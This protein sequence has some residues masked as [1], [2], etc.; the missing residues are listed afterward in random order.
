[1]LKDLHILLSEN[2]G[3]YLAE[4]IEP[5]KDATGFATP[6]GNGWPVE[7]VLPPPLASGHGLT[8][9]QGVLLELQPG[10][11]INELQDMGNYLF[12]FLFGPKD[13]ENVLYQY[14]LASFRQSQ[15][16]E[17]MR[18]VLHL[19]SEMLVGVPWELL[20][21]DN[22]LY[23][24]ALPNPKPHSLLRSRWKADDFSAPSIALPAALEPLRVLLIVCHS[25]DDD[26][27]IMG[28]E[29]A[30]KVDAALFKLLPWR[31]DLR[32]LV[33]PSFREVRDWCANWQPHVFHYVGHGGFN[34]NGPYLQFF[35]PGQLDTIPIDPTAMANFFTGGAPRLVVLNA[36]RSGQVA[37][38]IISASNSARASQSL[39]KVLIEGGVEAVI[40]MQADIDGQAA[41]YLMGEFYH[42][43]A[44]GGP[45]DL[46]L[47]AARQVY[48]GQAGLGTKKWDWA[49]PALYLSG[50]SRV[51]DVLLLDPNGTE[52]KIF[53]VAATDSDARRRLLQDLQL[54]VKIQVGR[55]KEQVALE[56]A[57]LKADFDKIAP[58][59][60]LYGEPFMGKTNMLY[61][62]SEGCARRGRQ[63]IYA[64]FAQTTLDYWD[65]LR[66]IRDG[67]L[68]PKVNGVALSNALNPDLIFN[69]FNY[70][71]NSKLVKGYATKNRVAPAL[72]T[73]VAD[74]TRDKKAPRELE[75]LGTVRSNEN[76]IETINEAF[77]SSLA[78]AADPHG[79]IIFLD[80]VDSMFSGEVNKLRNYL[81]N[82]VLASENYPN[83]R[84]VRMVLAVRSPS[85]DATTPERPWD[86]LLDNSKVVVQRLAGLPPQDLSWLARL[87]ARRYFI[88]NG[89]PLY[90]R[91]KKLTT[92]A[93]DAY[94]SSLLNNYYLSRAQRPGRLISD[95][96][97]P[98]RIADLLS[99][100][101]NG[102]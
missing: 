102:V 33:R 12:H 19:D 23:L 14:W 36:C 94:V 30:L 92:Q 26:G 43:L 44:E 11:A 53:Q 95:L 71:L 86:F 67:R 82:Q 10:D 81:V 45:L 97:N 37:G 66:L 77:W 3:K 51:E 80:N 74:L 39:A 52:A 8:D 7:L 58:V 31:V 88:S 98:D 4:V 6:T 46:A 100:A 90:M 54:R 17:G 101:D 42:K 55:D 35:E 83:A 68:E 62:L 16:E 64:D 13:H 87:W 72:N 38:Q 99:S 9:F 1:M 34:E 79:L 48:F 59:T 60:L 89:G 5:P 69:V 61:W 49:L 70:A 91:D 56:K 75:K 15:Q 2:K 32:V 96:L 29:E 85:V 47:T 27:R 22:G 78:R 20:C 50:G 28:P 25:P 93:I 40:A 24:A 65:A 18:T 84:M 57:L 76:P 73:I 21:N 63:F 41:A